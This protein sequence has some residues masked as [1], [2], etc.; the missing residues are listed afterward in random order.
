MNQNNNNSLSPD[1]E[2]LSPLLV[3]EKENEEC[4]AN[5]IIALESNW[6][7]FCTT[8]GWQQSFPNCHTEE[9][10]LQAKMEALVKYHS[11]VGVDEEDV[12]VDEEDVGVDEEDVW[13]DAIEGE[14]VSPVR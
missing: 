12:G 7:E 9:E 5:D 14:E 6:I 3:H 8:T 2:H 11:G 10:L 4:I 13:V 1:Q